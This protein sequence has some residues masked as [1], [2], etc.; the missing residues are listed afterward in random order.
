[1]AKSSSARPNSP[2]G[3]I[4]TT[5]TSQS[6]HS[7]TKIGPG[8]R[9]YTTRIEKP[10]PQYSFKVD[11]QTTTQSAIPDEV[12]LDAKHFKSWPGLLKLL[13]IFVAILCMIF[14]S[15]PLTW[16]T[17]ILCAVVAVCFAVTI[18]ICLFYLFTLRRVVMPKWPWLRIESLF[19]NGAAVSYLIA[20]LLQL[21]LTNR[22]DYKIALTYHDYYYDYLIAGALGLINFVLYALGGQLL[23]NKYRRQQERQ[24]KVCIVRTTLD[25]RGK[26][27]KKTIKKSHQT[28]HIKV[29]TIQQQV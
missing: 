4:I 3:S 9:K 19:T 20:S 15:P 27:V 24:P 17:R 26:P 23:H 10:R 25:R 29:H 21:I 12:E 14:F 13:Q 2:G 28:P 5:A 1:M 7:S 18:F 11:T 22:E 6:T 8:G 16:F